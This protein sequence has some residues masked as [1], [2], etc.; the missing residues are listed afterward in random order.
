[1]SQSPT[2][3][4]PPKRPRLSLQ[5]KNV[6]TPTSLGKS[7]TSLK[8]DIDPS[9]PTSF[10]TLSN[11]YA[12]AIENASPATARPPVTAISTRPT[13]LRLQTA[14][15][16][17]GYRI[18]SQ[19]TQTPGP[20][21]IVYPD[22]PSS[23]IEEL[24]P[25]TAHPKV[26]TASETPHTF[27]PPQSAGTSEQ[28]A[29]RVFTFSANHSSPNSPGSPRT[30]RRRATVGGGRFQVPPYTHPRS[31]RS[32]LRNSPLPPRSSV[33][34]ATPTRMSMRIAN[35]VAKKVGYN[36]P[37][38][39]TI[40]T[41]T[42][43]KSHIDLLAEESPASAVDPEIESSET[44]DVAMAYKGVETRDGGQTPGPFEEMR[45][46]MA[47]LGAEKEPDSP[48][49]R[50]RKRRREKKRKWVWTIGS[51]DEE[52]PDPIIGTPT[53]AIQ[54]A[55][56]TPAT[57]IWRGQSVDTTDSEKTDSEMSEISETSEAEDRP[58]T[59]YSI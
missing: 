17:D 57:A 41:N 44:L 47:G 12:A 8:A 51:N 15:T 42:Y 4:S 43:V 53:T 58:N 22:T 24:T 37:L 54:D 2:S 21:S 29:S 46:R 56:K 49:T 39:Q 40:V 18:P 52:E 16:G 31:L 11:A 19:R 45:R 36:E 25:V 6:A 50:R 23:A 28:P 32:I 34:P 14:I 55:G 5:I 20:Y 7:Q 1:M 3:Q 48:K 27:T 26:Y 30:P 10:N 13:S 59:S 35:R 38:T 33:T 9:S